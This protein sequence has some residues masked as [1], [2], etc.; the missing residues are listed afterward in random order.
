MWRKSKVLPTR[1]II[2]TRCGNNFFWMWSLGGIEHQNASPAKTAYIC[3]TPLWWTGNYTAS[4]AGY[5]IHRPWNVTMECNQFRCLIIQVLF[6]NGFFLMG[7][8]PGGRS[9][10]EFHFWF[11]QF[12]LWCQLM[13]VTNIVLMHINQ[14]VRIAYNDVNQRWGNSS[15]A[16]Q[17]AV[18][19]PISTLSG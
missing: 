6:L 9:S 14:T 17:Q 13:H 4:A 15:Y 12:H 5:I 16:L 11:C 8:P 3:T 19:E 2:A 18:L 7:S 1:K 10:T